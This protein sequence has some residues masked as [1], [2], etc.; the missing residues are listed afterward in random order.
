MIEGILMVVLVAYI[1]IGGLSAFHYEKR[2]MT[3]LALICYIAIWPYY[4][5]KG[6]WKDKG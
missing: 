2:F 1:L 4:V 5:Y 6:F 3:D